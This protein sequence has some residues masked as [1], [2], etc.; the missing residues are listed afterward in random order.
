MEPNA[1]DEHGTEIPV[2]GVTSMDHTADVALE[3]EAADPAEL[4]GRA[5][6]GM[7]YLLLERLPE[8]ADRSREL[9]LS[10]TDLPGLF[11]DWL[12]ELLFWHEDEGFV[13]ASADVRRLESGDG[14]E[15]RLEATVHGGAEREPPVRE[16]KGVT[17]H[18]LA[19]ERRDGGWYGRV[20]FDV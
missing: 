12:R 19:V 15:A 13:V 1:S 10:S 14:D 4:F 3:V 5:A 6:A 7:M 16:I 18:G 2:P 20:I 8:R 17:L 9:R 11:R